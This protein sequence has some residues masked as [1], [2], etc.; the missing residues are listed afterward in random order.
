MKVLAVLKTRSKN[1]ENVK[2]FVK[3]KEYGIEND[4]HSAA[5]RYKSTIAKEKYFCSNPIHAE[6]FK[7]MQVTCENIYFEQKES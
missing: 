4:A 7:G 3:S 1:S 6:G 2:I 5:G